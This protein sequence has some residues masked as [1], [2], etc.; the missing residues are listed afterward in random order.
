MNLIKKIALFIT[1]ILA[2]FLLSLS[3]SD[4]DYDFRTFL[5]KLYGTEWL[6][7]NEYFDT[8]LYIR[9]NNYEI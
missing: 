3:C 6:L 7:S 9:L 8:T 1:L 2:I 4:G 5:E